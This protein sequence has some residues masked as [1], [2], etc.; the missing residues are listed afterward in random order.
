M[1]PCRGVVQSPKEDRRPESCTDAGKYSTQRMN[2]SIVR[3]PGQENGKRRLAVDSLGLS[4][5]VDFSSL[6]PGHHQGE[7]CGHIKNVGPRQRSIYNSG[8][9]PE[10]ANQ[11]SW[12]WRCRRM[13][14]E[15]VQSSEKW[16]ELV[17]RGGGN[18]VRWTFRDETVTAS[19]Q[20]PQSTE[21]L[22]TRPPEC[23]S[24][25]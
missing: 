19:L 24:L 10:A 6:C 16:K 13:G 11:C 9:F 15:P 4:Q 21:L 5:T 2:Q 20:Q 23:Q 3:L 17:P 18:E 8:L 7:C 1:R 25:L 12:N 14:A 22:T